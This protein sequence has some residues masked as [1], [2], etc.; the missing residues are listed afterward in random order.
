MMLFVLGILTGGFTLWGVACIWERTKESYRR[1]IEIKA[2][3][4]KKEETCNKCKDF[5]ESDDLTRLDC[6]DYGQCT[7]HNIKVLA[8]S[9]CNSW[10]LK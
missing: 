9:S 10:R 1:A 7:K 6:Y 2:Y 8:R 4:I 3:E 5:K